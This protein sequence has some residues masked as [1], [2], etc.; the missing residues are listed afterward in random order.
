[1]YATATAETSHRVFLSR[2]FRAGRDRKW[3]GA[4]FASSAPL[5]LGRPP[6]LAISPPFDIL[7][8][9]FRFGGRRGARAG[10]LRM[11]FAAPQTGASLAGDRQRQHEGVSVACGAVHVILRER[12]LVLEGEGYWRLVS[13]LEW[14]CSASFSLLSLHREELCTWDGLG[15]RAGVVNYSARNDSTWDASR[16]SPPR[17]PCALWP[18]R[19][20]QILGGVALLV[21]AAASSGLSP[22]PSPPFCG[23]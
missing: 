8:Y 11:D 12:T 3:S 7:C 4:E 13:R 17:Q 9:I 21:A 14:R 10:N 19:P 5:K 16:G 1:M 18:P 2:G 6:R 23:R 20:R 15:R 22:Q